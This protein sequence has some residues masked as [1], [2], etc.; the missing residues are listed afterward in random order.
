MDS[1]DRP[2]GVDQAHR[3]PLRSPAFR[4]P[5]S[6]PTAWWAL[7]TMVRS[8][9]RLRRTGT[10]ALDPAHRSSRRPW[11]SPPLPVVV[12]RVG[13]HFH[14]RWLRLGFLPGLSNFASRPSRTDQTLLFDWV[15]DSVQ[16]A[17]GKRRLGE[18]IL[19]IG[20]PKETLARTFELVVELRMLDDRQAKDESRVAFTQ[21]YVA[22]FQP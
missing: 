16:S 5:G 6:A 20:W 18:R 10:A 1:G 11:R 17:L 13:N 9:T 14:K 3:V 22:Q 7:T 15:P 19:I 2:G 8:A 21:D 4:H 12:S